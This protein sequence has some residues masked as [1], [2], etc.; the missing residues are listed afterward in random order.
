MWSKQLGQQMSFLLVNPAC[1]RIVPKHHRHSANIFMK[2]PASV[3]ASD[4]SSMTTSFFFQ[5]GS[6]WD[7]LLVPI[8]EPLSHSLD[9]DQHIQLALSVFKLV[10]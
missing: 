4:Y 1:Q 8:K 6:K 10:R 7:R 2:T 9:N 3:I 5:L